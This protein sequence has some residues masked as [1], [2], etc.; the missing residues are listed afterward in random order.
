MLI[1]CSSNQNTPASEPPISTTEAAKP[2]QQ[3]TVE[4]LS[5]IT[6]SEGTTE[7]TSTY[8]KLIVNGKEADEINTS[9]REYI[10]KTYPMEKKGDYVDGYTVRYAWGAKD[11]TVSIVIIASAVSEDFF[12]SEVFNYDLD[13]LKPQKDSEVAKCLG[14]TDDEFFS[15]TA[16]IY[17]NYCGGR[18]DF[19][20]E[21]SIA[22]INYDKITPFIMPDGNPGVA[23][24][25]YYSADS[26]FGGLESVRCFNMSTMEME[27]FG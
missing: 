23:G 10:Q 24:C 13:T 6:L 19:D 5:R 20:L 15:K 4:E 14:M 9:L 16:D 17:R 18:A 12:T 8:P 1:G 3:V 2:S 26:Q 7:L 27:Y 11:N 25:V 22:A 21:K